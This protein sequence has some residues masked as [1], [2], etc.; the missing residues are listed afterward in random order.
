VPS[1]PPWPFERRLRRE[2]PEH[3]GACFYTDKTRARLIGPALTLWYDWFA[4]WAEKIA[5]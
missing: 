2:R 4:K 1:T 3:H 5:L